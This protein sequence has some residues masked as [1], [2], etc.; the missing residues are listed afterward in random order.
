MRAARD[1]ARNELAADT[2]NGS[3]Y[4]AGPERPRKLLPMVT[5]KAPMLMRFGGRGGGGSSRRRSEAE[6]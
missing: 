2:G 1:T 6:E 5:Q 3:P 4:P